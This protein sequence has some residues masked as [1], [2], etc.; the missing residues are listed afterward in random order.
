M[1]NRN[2]VILEFERKECELREITEMLGLV[3]ED[4]YGPLRDND[5]YVKSNNYDRLET[6]LINVHELLYIKLKEMQDFIEKINKTKE[7]KN[8]LY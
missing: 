7:D 3:V 5:L 1:I 4:Y 6:Y 2:D 8:E